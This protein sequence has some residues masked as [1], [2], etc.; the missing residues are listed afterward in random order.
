M[1]S[2]I[3]SFSHAING[4]VYAISSEKHLRFHLFAAVLVIAAGLFFAITITEWC[5]LILSIG[6]VITAELINTALEQLV[7]LVSPQQNI[8]AGRVKDV[9]A[10]AVLIIS[11]VAAIIGLMVFIPKIFSFINQ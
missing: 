7:N 4:I 5:I 2:E 3:K 11:I 1:K 8:I 10:G 6:A 9:A